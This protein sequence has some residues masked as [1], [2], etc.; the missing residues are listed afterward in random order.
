MTRHIHFR[1]PVLLVLLVCFAMFHSQGSMAASL[2]KCRNTDNIWNNCTGKWSDGK[3][4]T[5][6]GEWHDNKQNGYGTATWSNGEKY[7]GGYLN[8]EIH[9]KGTYTWANGDKYVGAYRNGKRN[10]HG[11]FAWSNGEVYVG[12]YSDDL[13]S[14][15]GTYTWP[16]GEKH[17]GEYVNG[18]RNGQGTYTWP[19][20]QKFTGEYK[21]DDRVGQGIHSWP[22]GAKY[23]GEFNRD[24]P[25]GQG[26]Y[27]F[28]DGSAYTGFFTDWYL[29]GE[30]VVQY[31]NGDSFS[32]TYIKDKR[33]GQ[34]TY[35]WKTG[36]KYVGVWRDGL[37]SGEGKHFLANGNELKG[38]TY[39]SAAVYD[40]YGAVTNPDILSYDGGDEIDPNQAITTQQAV[41][42]QIVEAV[43]ASV[44][45]ST[46]SAEEMNKRIADLASQ[47]TTLSKILDEQKKQQA[48]AVNALEKPTIDQTIIAINLR[49]DSLRKEFNE[50]D[51]VFS[52]YLTSVKPND[53]DLYLT[54]RKASQLYPKVPYYIPGTNETGEFWVEPKVTDAGE[55]IFN[56]RLIDLAAENDTTRS[57]IAMDLDQLK[58]S[59]KA[60]FKLHKNSIIAHEK[61]IRENYTKRVVCFPAYQCPE[62]NQKGE[63]G[64]SS[65]EVIFMI[66][67]DGSTGGRLQQNKGA[68]QEGVNF[69]IDGAL[70]LQA[71]LSHVIQEATLE[72]ESG[73]R[74]KEQLDELFE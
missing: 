23:V 69:S 45:L 74:T 31:S 19:N 38:A 22:S 70:L 56:V 51:K 53:R 4:Y 2:K 27:T 13:Q 61:K 49:I 9:G 41:Q 66:Y 64:K 8:G 16:N 60:L 1:F 47:L 17:V 3:G 37:P 73:T 57:L 48:D 35:N 65:T 71:Y 7:V 18:K 54:A 68:F 36:G 39:R 62:E 44:E 59:Q 20:G 5:Y 15:R 46:K 58:Q 72:F 21:N 10:G 50:K 12:E 55:L 11:T 67:E 32:G 40:S 43:N 34:G 33:V 28:A 52:Q 25:N 29:Y 26:T 30:T 24:R 42:Q 14:G 63:K 6:N